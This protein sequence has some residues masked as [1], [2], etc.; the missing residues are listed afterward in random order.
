MRKDVFEKNVVLFKSFEF[1][2]GILDY[3]EKL[4]EQKKFVICNQLLK[5]GTSIGANIM[6]AQNSESKADFI[7]K[8]KVSAKEAG[9]T[10][11]WLML[12]SHAKDYPECGNLLTDLEEIQKLLSRILSTAKK[13]T[14]ISYLLSF[15]IF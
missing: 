8:V 10:Q 13:K 3:C 2:L 5:S 15:I 11:F 7:H 12:C 14:P 1:A 4:G 6:E 9:E